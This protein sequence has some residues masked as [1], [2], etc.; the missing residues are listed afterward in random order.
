M[1]IKAHRFD[2]NESNGSQ[3]GDTSLYRCAPKNGNMGTEG[4]LESFRM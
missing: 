3:S 2:F 1:Y 4:V